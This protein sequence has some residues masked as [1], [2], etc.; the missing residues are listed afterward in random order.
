[1]LRRLIAG[2]IFMFRGY[3][4]RYADLDALHGCG[5]KPKR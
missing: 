3:R 1:M 5:Y 2:I 4:G